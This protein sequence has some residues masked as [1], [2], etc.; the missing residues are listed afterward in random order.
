MDGVHN[1]LYMHDYFCYGNQ[2]DYK[3]VTKRYNIDI[4]ALIEVCMIKI[5]RS[6]KQLDF[7]Q[8]M[9]VYEQ[10]NQVKGIRNYPRYSPYEQSIRMEEETYLYLRDYLFA[11]G[12]GF[13]GVWEADGRYVAALRMEPYQEKTWLLTALETLPTLRSKGYGKKLVQGVLAY[14]EEMGPTTVYAHI[15]KKNQASITVHKFCGFL[16]ERDYA[17]FLDGSVSQKYKTFRYDSA[18]K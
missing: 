14:L 2:N 5:I 1:C 18:K 6:T 10:S 12:K 15:E 11:D 17:V 9:D 8:L 3:I 16:P 13:C 7:R 4:F